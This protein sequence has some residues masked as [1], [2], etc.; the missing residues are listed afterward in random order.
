LE[1]Q[2][3][4]KTGK[5]LGKNGDVLLETSSVTQEKRLLEKTVDVFVFSHVFSEVK[6]HRV[7][8]HKLLVGKSTGCQV[9]MAYERLPT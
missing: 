9:F 7:T 6:T 5:I 8:F 1:F 3:Q 2:P 4:E